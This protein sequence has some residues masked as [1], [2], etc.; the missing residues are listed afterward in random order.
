MLI[1]KICT[2]CCCYLFTAHLK[3][4][5]L[6]CRGLVRWQ[7]GRLP[8]CIVKVYRPLKQADNFLYKSMEPD[9]AKYL[10]PDPQGHSGL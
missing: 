1:G 5:E 10:D 9:P 4:D 3:R 7:G 2:V 6:V 8:N